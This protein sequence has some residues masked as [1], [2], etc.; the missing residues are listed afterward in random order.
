MQKKILWVRFTEA[1]DFPTFVKVGRQ[2][3]KDK[4]NSASS[5]M[6]NLTP[7]PTILQQTPKNAA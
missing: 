2:G 3:K 6:A 7:W 1:C 5:K 4:T